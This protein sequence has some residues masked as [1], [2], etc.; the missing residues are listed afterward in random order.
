MAC[1]PAPND[2]VKTVGGTEPQSVQEFVT[3][4]KRYY[5]IGMEKTL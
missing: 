1:S 2:I 5:S 4:N 3:R